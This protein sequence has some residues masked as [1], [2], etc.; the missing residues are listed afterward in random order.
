MQR[1]YL[2]FWSTIA[3][4]CLYCTIYMSTFSRDKMAT[5]NQNKNVLS[6]WVVIAQKQTLHNHLPKNQSQKKQNTSGWIL[7]TF[8]FIFEYGK[9]SW[10]KTV[11][12][13]KKQSLMLEVFAVS[14]IFF[15][16]KQQNLIFISILSSSRSCFGFLWQCMVQNYQ[17][18]PMMN[19]S[20]EW[21]LEMQWNLLIACILYSDTSL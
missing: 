18:K 14:H 19:F 7:S 16:K 12:W 2:T 5:L 20:A 8:A 1:T 15:K 13:S 11:K 21:V 6:K 17:I 4:R 9:H 10:K 3:E